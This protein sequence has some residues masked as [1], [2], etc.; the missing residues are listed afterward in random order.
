MRK[1]E[2]LNR[3]GKPRE[4]KKEYNAQY[5]IA[6]KERLDQCNKQRYWANVE[7]NA[8]KAA[9]RYERDGAKPYVRAQTLVNACRERAEKKNIP[10][11]IT[12]TDLLP[13]LESGICEA[14]GLRFIL[15][16]RSGRNPFSPSVDRIVLER[17]YVPGNI[18][19]IVWALN[20]AC[21]DWGED[22]LKQI[23]RARWPEGIS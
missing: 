12:V 15:E 13:A 4:G 7:G 19:V 6:N 1:W 8:E 21:G 11:S 17:G 2:Q 3:A 23:V 16:R 22:I 5:Y 9:R 14:T 18:R 20:A 10:F